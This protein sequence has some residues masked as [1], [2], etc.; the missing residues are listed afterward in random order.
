MS[1]PGS[2]RDRWIV[3][4]GNTLWRTTEMT[5]VASAACCDGCLRQQQEGA[6]RAPSTISCSGGPWWIRTIDQNIKSSQ[7][8]AAN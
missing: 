8:E 7:P 3:S 2:Y 5:P 6:H 4:I 1:A